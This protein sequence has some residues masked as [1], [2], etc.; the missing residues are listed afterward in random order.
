[1]SVNEAIFARDSLAKLLYSNLFSYLVE[2][3]NLSL[4]V[5]SNE[6]EMKDL[7][8]IGVL[9]IFG[10]EIFEENSFEQFW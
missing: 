4:G 2:K 10:F 9:D 3:I 8:F 6:K 5:S 1:L 7:K